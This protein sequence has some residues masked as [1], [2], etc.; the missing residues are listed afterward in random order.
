MC[1]A[2]HTQC[3]PSVCGKNLTGDSGG[4]RTHDLLLNSADVLTSRPPSLPDDDRPARI[5]YSSGF[6]DD[7]L[8]YLFIFLESL[9]VIMSDLGMSHWFTETKTVQF[10]HGG[11]NVGGQIC[12]FFRLTP[13][14]PAYIFS[15]PLCGI[16]FS[17][18]L[19]KFLAITNFSVNETMSGQPN[20]RLIH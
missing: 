19:K 17:K 5:L 9:N 16:I 4:I 14:L 20:K 18:N 2:L 3:F 6:R 7:K 15:G 1:I 13:S 11:S 12:F 8:M 10:P